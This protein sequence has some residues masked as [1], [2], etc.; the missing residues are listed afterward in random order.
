MTPHGGKDGIIVDVRSRFIPN[1]ERMNVPS[2][3]AL[4]FNN[5]DILGAGIAVLTVPVEELLPEL[6]VVFHKPNSIGHILGIGQGY[7][8]NIGGGGYVRIN[9]RTNTSK[10]VPDGTSTLGAVVDVG[11]LK[12]FSGTSVDVVVSIQFDAGAT[13]GRLLPGNYFNHISHDGHLCGS[14]VIHLR[15]SSQFANFNHCFTSLSDFLE[16]YTSN[17]VNRG[18]RSQRAPLKW[19]PRFTPRQ[20]PRVRQQL[21]RWI[22]EH[23]ASDPGSFYRNGRLGATASSSALPA[24]CHHTA[25]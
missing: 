6:L 17:Q 7:P 23:P 1:E 3:S 18:C 5:A 19:G 9:Q 20:L 12:Y 24:S 10:G 2:T 8:T 25:S 4:W 16:M 14:I 15:G 21:L 22:L 13:T 11:I